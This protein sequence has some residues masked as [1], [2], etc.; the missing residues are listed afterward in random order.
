MFRK[1]LQPAPQQEQLG[2]SQQLKIVLVHRWTDKDGV[3]FIFLEEQGR[4][5]FITS[6]KYNIKYKEKNEYV[7]EALLNLQEEFKNYKENIKVN[8][9]S[10]ICDDNNI[11]YI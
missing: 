11:F 10:N 5:V 6:V 2:Q 7:K 3:H 8:G 4:K 9:F 1:K